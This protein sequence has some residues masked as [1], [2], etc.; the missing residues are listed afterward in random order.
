MASGAASHVKPVTKQM[1]GRTSSGAARGA[2]P[3]AL[4]NGTL[5]VVAQRLG[6]AQHPACTA[7]SAGSSPALA[8]G[9]PVHAQAQVLPA[10]RF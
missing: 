3:E 7:C 9:G 6:P 8:A 10:I 4:P 1:F 2:A 5:N